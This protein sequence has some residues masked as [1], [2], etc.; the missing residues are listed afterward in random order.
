MDFLIK[1]EVDVNLLKKNGESLIYIV[2]NFGYFSIVE[3]LLNNNVNN[4][5]CKI[6]WESFLYVVCKNGYER[7]V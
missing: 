3:F 7:I 1:K 2:S 4:N 6:N 5:L